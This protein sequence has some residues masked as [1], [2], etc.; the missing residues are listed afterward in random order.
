QLNNNTTRIGRALPD[1]RLH[2]L[3]PYGN[4]TPIGVIGELYVSGAGL[5]RGYEARPALTAERFVPDHLGQTPGARLYR[6]GDLARWTPSGDLEYLGRADAQVKIRGYRIELGEIEAQLAQMAGLREAVALP[7]QEANGRTDLV[8]YLVPEPGTDRPTTSELRDALADHLPDYMIPR[9][10]VLLDAL[11][12]TPQGKLDRR[13][14]PAPTTERPTLETEFAPPLPGT[15]E[16]LATIWA[17]ILGVDRIGRHDNF[18]DLGGDSIRSIQI[19]GRARDN[20]IT[21]HLQDLFHHPT[22]ADLATTTTQPTTTPPTTQPFSLLTPH[23]RNHLPHHLDDAYPMAELQ[24]GMVYEMQRDP[25]RNPYLNVTSLHLPGRFEQQAFRAAV[26]MVVERHPVLRT[27]FDLSG[28]SVPMQ[29]VHAEAEMPLGL[30]DLRGLSKARQRREL[31]DYVRGERTTGFDPAVAPLFRMTVHVLSDDA[32]QWTVTDHHAIL[33]GWSL[34]STL[35]EITD[36]Y[37]TLLNGHTPTLPPL[38]STYRD[39]I[40]AEQNAL[41]N[42]AHTTYWHNLLTDR[43]DTRLP[44]HSGDGTPLLIGERLDGEVHEHDSTGG[45]GALVTVV[46]PEL[47]AALEDSAARIGVPFK[48]VVLA[49]HMRVLSLVTGSADVVTGLSSNGRLEETDGTE[50]RGL[51]LNSLP[52]RLRL[53]DG[54][55]ADLARAVFDAEREMLPHRRY[56]MPALQRALGGDPLFETGFVYNHFRHVDELAE[57]GRASVSGPHDETAAGVARTSFPLHVAMSREPGLAGMRMEL[58]YDAREFP[59]EQMRLIRDYHLRA[60]RAIAENPDGVHRAAV[61]LGEAERALLERWNDNAAAVPSTPVHE[62][63]EARAA[64]Q[65]HRVA[66]VAGERSLTYGE[67]DARADRL[68][69]HLRRLGVGPEVFVGVG[70]DRSPELVVGL[71]AVLKAGGAYVPLDVSFPAARL[72]HMLREADV[73][74]VLAG[75]STRDLVPRG[76]WETVDVDTVVLHEET[77]RGRVPEAGAGPDNA[78]YAIFTSG[79]TGR[80]KGVVTRHRNV[81]ELLHGGPAMELREDDTVL[82]IA[83]VAFDVSTFEIWAPLAAGARLVLAPPGRYAPADV[84]GWVTDHGVTVLH[85]TASLFTLLVDEQPQT[86]DGLRRLLTGSE[87]VSAPHAGRILARCPELELVNCWGPTETTTF[88]V[89]GIFTADSLPAGLLPLGTPLANTEVRVLDEAGHPVPVGS[90]GELYVAGPCLARGYLGRPALTAEHFLPHP[91]VPGARLYRTGDRGRWSAE[92]QVEFL[93]RVDHMVKIRGYRVEPGEVSAAIGAHPRVRQCVV[94]APRDTSGRADLVGYVVCDAPAPDVTELRS[95]LREK[96]PEYMLPKAFVFLDAF[97]LTAQ[98]KVDRDRL[99]APSGDRPELSAQYVAPLPGVE[100]RLAVIW[101]QVL[102]LDRIGRHDNFFDLGGDSIRSIQ[103]IGRAREEG[104]L[105]TLPVLFRSP[106]LAALGTEVTSVAADLLPA[107]T[108]EPFALLSAEDRQALPE[109]LVDAYPMAALQVGMVYEMEIDPDRNP[110]HNVSTVR[111]D[112]RFEED[113][114]R[115]AV[116]LTVGRHDVLRT[117]F[118][119]SGYSKPVQLVHDRAESP[120][121]VVDLRGQDDGAQRAAVAECVRNEQDEGFSVAAAPL[122]RMTVHVLSDDAF[123]WTVTDHHAILDGW[124]LASTLAEITDTYHTLLD[125]STPSLPPLRSTYRD[126]IAAEQAALTDPAHTT[127]WHNLLNDRPDTRLP[128][129]TTA[130]PDGLAGLCSAGEV[131]R[132]DAERRHG[133]LITPLPVGLGVGLDRFARHCG[134]PLKSVMLAAHLR[135]MSLATGSRDVVTGLSSN[136]RLEETDGTEARGLFLNTLPFRL[137]LPEGSWRDLVRTVF[138]AEQDML[139]HRR[140]PMS[141]IQRELGG[142]PLFETGFVYNHFRQ[143]DTLAGGADTDDD[144]ARATG[145]GRT[146]FPLLVA[147]SQEPGHQGLSLEMEYD[148]GELSSVQVALMRDYYVRVLESMVCEPDTA[149]GDVVLLG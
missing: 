54:S 40:A 43:P 84:A 129:H 108:T 65:P 9:N 98:G 91:S 63:V 136:G 29:L 128:R 21:F 1:L 30:V 72:A 95:A 52:F 12:L 41:T 114:F 27:S 122:F 16:A 75:A 42:P 83:T 25:D 123:Q 55:W 71:L 7:Y 50:V 10:F 69:R 77:R 11:P 143:I 20:G 132:N 148:I 140:Y 70:L 121:T 106:T 74:V 37:H 89:C 61:L 134:V 80:P 6:S 131:Q 60:L 44:R 73:R 57:G 24:I 107:P 99:P 59:A 137:E 124:S 110:Y 46:P 4:P 48:A 35:A 146:H 102:G 32:F 45:Y 34:A 17:D 93:G 58:E 103:V 115:R 53:P 145:G 96:L 109:G 3:D 2:V 81:T 113:A 82:Q 135:V 76:P 117:S 18:F 28:L 87:T 104:L 88:S 56:P 38:R 130:L 79:S 144:H 127:Y 92:G 116:E 125:G 66:V 78:C 26:S 49:A 139:P 23:D 90:P 33:D 100:E 111:L 14:L 39:Y 149:F 142:E 126:Y 13:S 118:D 64:A 67:L 138:E 141:A 147:V 5:A 112:E 36:T 51:F 97:P 94:T 101:R 68:A 133:E 15:E 85:A 31:A 22:L 62:L 47:L 86:F 8:A 105:L 19:L 119:L 120:L